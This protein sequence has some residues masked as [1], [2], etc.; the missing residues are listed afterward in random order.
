MSFDLY[1]LPS[2]KSCAVIERKNPFGNG[3]ESVPVL[4]PETMAAV[5]T[6]LR[7]RAAAK[8]DDGSLR[9]STPDGGRADVLLTRE[10]CMFAVRSK[11][12]TD[13]AAVLFEV[14][15][16]GKWIM[17]AASGE[18]VIANSQTYAEVLPEDAGEVLL[19]HAADDLV[20]H[21]QTD[22]E[23]WEKVRIKEQ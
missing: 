3:S 16:A 19:A 14:L 11:V 20:R 12:T 7:S 6:V 1:F 4:D 10:S 15:V 21:L 2:R 8:S 18:G 13:L 22:L 5:A 9:L 17:F 23:R